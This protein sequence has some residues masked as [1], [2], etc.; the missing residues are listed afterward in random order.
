MKAETQR[1]IG[2]IAAWI[3]S[4]LGIYQLI[5]NLLVFTS[6]QS[7]YWPKYKWF[8]F[9]L[10]DFLYIAISVTYLSA[11]RRRKLKTVREIFD[12]LF[13]LFFFV[14]GL[15]FLGILISGKWLESTENLLLSLIAL[16]WVGVPFGLNIFLLWLGV[17]GLERIEQD[18]LKSITESSTEP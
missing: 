12:F 8:L 13:V 14:L 2:E 11:I 18:K 4:I 9:F 16:L 3:M 15:T 5:S 7:S 6:Y 1:K 10:I 17:R